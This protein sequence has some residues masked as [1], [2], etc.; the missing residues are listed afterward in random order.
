[1]VKP[2]TAVWA[3]IVLAALARCGGGCSARSTG[4]STGPPD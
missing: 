3:V 1:M 2:V 4:G